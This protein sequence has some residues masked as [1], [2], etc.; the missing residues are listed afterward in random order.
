VNI[1]RI[2]M[3]KMENDKKENGKKIDKKDQI[4]RY[5]VDFYDMFDGW[6]TFGFFNERLF[7]ELNDA[8]KLCDKLNEELAK[9]NKACGEHYGVMDYNTNMEVYCGQDKE[10]RKKIFAGCENVLKT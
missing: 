3:S 1:L 5:Y 6:G 10:Y 4:K 9:G 7:E 8:I 2:E